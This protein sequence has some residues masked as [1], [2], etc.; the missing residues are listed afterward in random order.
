MKNSISIIIV[1]IALISCSDNT[2]VAVTTDY[3]VSVDKV[4]DDW[5]ENEPGASIAIIRNGEVEY[6]KGYGLANMEYGIA[7]S[8]NTVFRIAPTHQSNLRLPVL[9][10]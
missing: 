10:C 1:S 5:N 4:F 2:Q 6:A 8:P 3:S 7:N 9:S